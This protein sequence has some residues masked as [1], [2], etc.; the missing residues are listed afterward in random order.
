M[1]NFLSKNLITPTKTLNR[2]TDG[3]YQSCEPKSHD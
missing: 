3:M 2:R 1:M